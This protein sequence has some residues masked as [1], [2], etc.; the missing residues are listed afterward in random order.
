MYY[1]DNAIEKADARSGTRRLQKK[2]VVC[3]GNIRCGFL[4]FNFDKHS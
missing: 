1:S 3:L 2:T 4:Y